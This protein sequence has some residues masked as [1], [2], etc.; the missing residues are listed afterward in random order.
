MVLYTQINKVGQIPERASQRIK[1]W[2]L[3][4]SGKSI[5]I[6]IDRQKNIRT[7]SQNA[8][9]HGGLIPQVR[10]ILRE[11]AKENGD[12]D[13]YL[14]DDEATKEWIKERF[15]GYETKL[16]FDEPTKFLRKTSLLDI[17]EF[18][19]MIENCVRFFSL[20]GFEIQLP[21]DYWN[22]LEKQKELEKK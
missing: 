14:I 13:W 18:S 5:K 6:D 15:L 12:S 4:H 3:Q 19:E 17:Y 10:E 21:E 11:W 20:K 7:L 22:W 2:L 16:I 9:L 1:D 8:F